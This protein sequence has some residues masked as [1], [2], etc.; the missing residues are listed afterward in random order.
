MFILSASRAAMVFNLSAMVFN[1]SA[2]T[3]KNS[4]NARARSLLRT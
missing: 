1:L 4:P 3:L 2:F